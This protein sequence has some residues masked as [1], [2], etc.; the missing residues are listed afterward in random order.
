MIMNTAR[1]YPEWNN[2]EESPLTGYNVF[3]F[4]SIR[5]QEEFDQS[6]HA[7]RTHRNAGIAPEKTLRITLPSTPPNWLS[8]SV[9]DLNLLLT[10]EENWDSYGARKT[11]PK[12]AVHAL[13]LLTIVMTN[14]M[15][16]PTIVPTPLGGVQLEWHRHGIDLEIEICGEGDYSVFFEDETG[17][18]ETWDGNLTRNELRTHQTI[19]RFMNEL[20]LRS[21]T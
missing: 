5:P 7:W 12:S 21:L 10:L 15:P 11:D 1:D 3:P 17:Q 14:D 2:L 19:S 20:S 8:A 4:P 9:D 16:D 6:Q 13:E 18:N